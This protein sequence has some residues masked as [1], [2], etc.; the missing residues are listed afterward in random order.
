[1]LRSLL[2][3]LQGLADIPWKIPVF[4]TARVFWNGSKRGILQLKILRLASRSEIEKSGDI[5]RLREGIDAVQEGTRAVMNRG[6]TA[7]ALLAYSERLAPGKRMSELMQRCDALQRKANQFREK[8]HD[9]EKRM[10]ELRSRVAELRQALEA[11]DKEFESGSGGLADEQPA[12][13]ND[14]VTET[15]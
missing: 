12:G 14:G 4:I 6:R 9:I 1:M 8:V 5:D 3:R 11:L 7:N 10:A 2:R 15:G 13:A